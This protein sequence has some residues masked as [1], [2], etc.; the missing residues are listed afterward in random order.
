MGYNRD[1]SI[2][3]QLFL[4]MAEKMPEDDDVRSAV[5]WLVHWASGLHVSHHHRSSE[6]VS[7]ENPAMIES[8]IPS[9]STALSSDI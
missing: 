4:E 9:I 5:F 2:A 7:T 1:D 8:R 3:L 6:A